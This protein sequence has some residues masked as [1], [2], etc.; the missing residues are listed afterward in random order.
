MIVPC[1]A[2][3]AVNRIAESP[4]KDSA[5]RCGACG[6]A[7]QILHARDARGR[8]YEILELQ[9]GASREEVKRAY[10]DLVKIWHPDR[11]SHDPRLQQ[12][13]QDKLKDINEAYERL[14]AGFATGASQLGDW[15][16]E[17]HSGRASRDSRSPESQEPPQSPSP[18]GS[19]GKPEQEQPEEPPVKPPPPS[20][21]QSSAKRKILITSLSS[22]VMVLMILIFGGRGRRPEQK[23]EAV[24]SNDSCL[25]NLSS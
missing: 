14:Q 4:R 9:P 25:T 2:C 22:L 10:R 11:F 8:Y 19:F 3:G 18:A 24:P 12:K 16:R 15:S 7:L 23:T 17:P 6:R 21:T 1:A 5:Y 13:A 20:S